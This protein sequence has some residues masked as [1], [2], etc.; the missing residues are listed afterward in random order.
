M[1]LQNES[2]KCSWR[3][4]K[5]PSI[6][7]VFTCICLQ[8]FDMGFI[9]ISTSHLT[10]KMQ[11]RQAFISDRWKGWNI[12]H[13]VL[14]IHSTSLSSTPNFFSL[15]RVFRYVLLRFPGFPNNFWRGFCGRNLLKARISSNGKQYPLPIATNQRA[16]HQQIWNKNVAISN[17][18]TEREKCQWEAAPPQIDFLIKIGL[19][20]KG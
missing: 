11:G 5:P 20:A 18:D 17:R 16:H 12:I 1:F 14:F 15:F 7:L 13:E 4:I 19:Q 2:V 9:I 6:K 3:R 10:A 8:E